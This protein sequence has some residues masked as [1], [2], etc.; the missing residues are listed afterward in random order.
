M[1]QFSTTNDLVEHLVEK[2]PRS[3]GKE[4]VFHWVDDLIGLICVYDGV[5]VIK[6]LIVYLNINKDSKWSLIDNDNADSSCRHY[7]KYI[8]N[9]EDAIHKHEEENGLG[10]DLDF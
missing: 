8:S 1:L 4:L 2:Y 7:I 6:G 3:K 9:M 10:L 5:E